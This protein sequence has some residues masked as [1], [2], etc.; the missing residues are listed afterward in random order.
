MALTQK[1]INVLDPYT[2]EAVGHEDYKNP[3]T[4]WLALD[5]AD[6]T[7]SKKFSLAQFIISNHFEAANLT[8]VIPLVEEDFGTAYSDT[9]YYLEIQCYKE[10]TLPIGGSDVT[11][12][13]NVPYHSLTKLTTGFSIV[14]SET[15]DVVISY[16]AFA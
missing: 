10:I 2:Q 7:E 5:H 8:T 9:T 14:V 3:T 12:R 4:V 13:E 11:L 15:T 16:F 6:W 1:R